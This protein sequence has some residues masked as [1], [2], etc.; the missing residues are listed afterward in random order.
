MNIEA[1]RQ[2]TAIER[3]AGELLREQEEAK[4]ARGN[5]GGQGAK[6]VRSNNATTQTLAELGISKA[7]SSRWQQL[8]NVPQEQFEGALANY[9]KPVRRHQ[10][11]GS[12]LS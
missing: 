12:A 10:S 6:I 5:P 4:G 3:K 8:A 11:R 7:Q 9:S 2:A 1:E